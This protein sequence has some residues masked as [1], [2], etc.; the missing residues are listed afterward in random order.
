MGE[1]A[2]LRRKL[3]DR[4]LTTKIVSN[5]QLLNFENVTEV[6]LPLKPVKHGQLMCL[7][8]TFYKILI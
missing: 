8:N 5:I 3:T 7:I 4:N 6:K 1:V 2:M